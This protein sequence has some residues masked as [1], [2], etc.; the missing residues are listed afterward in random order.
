MD[1]SELE[2]ARA[3]SEEAFGRLVEP[4]RRELLSHC[5]RM[6]GSLHD[7]ED[8]LQESLLRAWRGLAGFE[9]RSSLRTWLHRI[10]T[11][12]CLDS[13]SGS[14]LRS[15][16][17]WLSAAADPRGEM[18][19]PS[20][21]PIWL[22]PFPDGLLE[23]GASNPEVRYS[24]RESIALAFL[25]ALQSLPPRQRAT[26]LLRDVLGFA[27]D[28]VAELLDTSVAAVNSALQ[29]ARETLDAREP[30]QQSTAADDD[31]QRDLLRRYV[32]VW[33]E[34]DVDALVALLR[35]DATLSMPPYSAW[36]AG[37]EAIVRS[38]RQMVLPPEARGRF[39]LRVTR[40]NGLAALGAY[41]RAED[42]TFR[43][44]AI[45]LLAL[46]D[47]RIARI[48]AFLGN[49]PFARFGLPETPQG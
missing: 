32:R 12:A 28:E 15:L 37:A 4:H 22:E 30:S 21:E 1:P 13:M 33:E 35:E 39:K 2:A 20:S 5:Y 6:S 34:A 41:A 16:P 27:A 23:E 47:G 48:T 19:A 25:V 38:L 26:L 11:H 8:A 45:H 17:P 46:R 3:G 10:T 24:A 29:R 42:G 44:M 49:I 7:A 43:P 14:R 36:F 40:A 31:R 18:A 9:G